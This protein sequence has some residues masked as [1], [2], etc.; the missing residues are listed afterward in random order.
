MRTHQMI[1]TVHKQGRL[2]VTCSCGSV[3]GQF[4][5]NSP[6]EVSRMAEEAHATHAEDASMEEALDRLRATDWVR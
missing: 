2:F 4:F 3:L 5:G 6:E 1:A